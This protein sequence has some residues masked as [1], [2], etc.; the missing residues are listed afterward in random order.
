[1]LYASKLTNADLI[2]ELKNIPELRGRLIIADSAEPNRI[3]E[4]KRAG[5]NIVAAYKIVKDTVDYV[6]SKPLRI[7][8]ESGNLMREIKK[9]SWKT[10]KNGLLLDEIVKFEDH[11]CDAG[12]YASF[13]FNQPKA[14]FY[15]Q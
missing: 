15:S 12:R 13:Y 11:L 14:R 3:E 2:R 1:M 4:I 8:G 10:D 6:K 9:L 5:F 7:H